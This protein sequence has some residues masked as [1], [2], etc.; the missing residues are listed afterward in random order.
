MANIEKRVKE[1][2]AN[3]LGVDQEEV[4]PEASFVED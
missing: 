3:Q 1:I 2:I 4:V